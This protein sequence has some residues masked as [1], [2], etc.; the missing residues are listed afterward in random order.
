MININVYRSMHVVVSDSYLVVTSWIKDGV[1]YQENTA[2]LLVYLNLP[3]LLSVY[4]PLNRMYKH[5]Q[6]SDAQDQ[7]FSVLGTWCLVAGTWYDHTL[8]TRGR[9]VSFVMFC[10]L[11]CV[12]GAW[13]SSSTWY[14]VPGTGTPV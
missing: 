5:M 12:T 10:L 7:S 11:Y 8:L 4:Q 14:Q 13:Y 6:T 3:A 2:K 9:V 1:Y